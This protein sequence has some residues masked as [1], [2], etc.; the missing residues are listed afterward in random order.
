MD[1]PHVKARH[2]RVLR[3]AA[4]PRRG[5]VRGAWPAPGGDAVAALRQTADRKEFIGKCSRSAEKVRGDRFGDSSWPGHLS[6]S[7]RTGRMPCPRPL[8]DLF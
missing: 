3:F 2:A 5:V 6:A 7:I 4:Q 1:H 8:A